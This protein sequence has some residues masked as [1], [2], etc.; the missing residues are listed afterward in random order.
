MRLG[1]K[2]L[3]AP[4]VLTVVAVVAAVIYGWVD[5]RQSELL[6]ARSNAAH[7]RSVAVALSREE[8]AGV[9]GDVY[10]GLVLLAS[11][12]DGQVKTLREDL[13]K[14]VGMVQK[15]LATNLQA[16]ASDGDNAQIVGRISAH[17]SDFAK[18][19]DKAI[20]LSGIDPNVGA[21]SMRAA[22]DSFKALSKEL[23][24]LAVETQAQTIGMHNTT[25]SSQKQL[26]MVLALVLLAAGTGAAILAW[27]MSSRVVKQLHRAV[28]LCED[29]ANGKLA[30]A[31]EPLNDL[32]AD[33]IGD[34]Q[35]ALS[36]M[37]RGLNTALTTVRDAT[38]QISTASAE[39]AAGNLD[40]SQRT[41]QGASLL[42]QTATAMEQLT[43]TVAQTAESARTANQLAA[44][45]SAVAQRGGEAVT[46]VVS[47]M[48]EINSSS[49]RIADIIG[50]IDGIAFQTNILAL[51]AAV[52]AAR[53]GE[54]GRGFA[55][56][57]SEVRSLAQRSAAA[58][59]EIKALIGASV[60]RVEVGTQQVAS[61]G[62][63]MSEIVAS[64][65]RVSD[66]IGEITV[67][68]TEQSSGIGQVNGS[69]VNLDNMTQQN[70]AL[71]EESAAAAES[72]KQ[73]ANRLAGVV[74]QFDL[75]QSARAAPAVKP[76]GVEQPK[77]QQAAGSAT[78]PKTPSKAKTSVPTVPLAKA[79][80]AATAPV[81]A[82]AAA[83]VSKAAPNDADWETF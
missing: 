16:G 30:N 23:D 6:L 12:D 73:Q 55:V 40:L 81:P 82:P 77:Q 18:R 63:T 35:R 29:T 1:L 31:G 11:L 39:I 66:I 51:N 75:G 41:E 69:V 45:A 21:G 17:L 4:A 2:M 60:E 53:A 58:A 33:E 38:D 70:A 22:E 26:Q 8:L 71:V 59:R 76:N 3:L 78:K 19:C 48:Q 49:R 79:A 24:Q 10:R 27:R 57:A 32:S 65:Q 28:A 83:P 74:S 56:V 9:R 42:Q 50:T 44:S 80:R 64:V 54:Q 52:E 20:D 14:R 5:H 62:S 25:R 46:Q 47:T 72:L 7:E 36:Q 61:A 15:K 68:A 37:V 34:L 13:A 43:G 67:A